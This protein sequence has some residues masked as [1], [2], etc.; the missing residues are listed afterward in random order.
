MP[1]LSRRHF[2]KGSALLV[3]AYATHRSFGTDLNS[4]IRIAVVGLHWRGG[5]LI[6]DVMRTKG[7]RLV[8]LCDVDSAELTKAAA[9]VKSKHGITVAQVSEFRTLL[10]RP[11]IDAVAIAT[12]NHWHA[13]QAIWALQAGKDVYLEKPVCHTLW[14]GR[15]IIRAASKYNK[16]VQ[17]GLQNRSDI[18]LK[19][20]FAYIQEG[21]LGAIK[22]VRGL[23][24]KNRASIG[25]RSTP[26]TP[27][28]SLNY[29]LWLGPAADQP[30]FR[31]RIHYDWHWDWN[32]G[33][34]DLGNQG[35]HELDL[36]RWVL[37]EPDHPTAV[38]SM[39]RRFAWHDAGQTPNM[40]ICKLH[41]P[42]RDVIFEV[43]NLWM[44]PETDAASHYKGHRIGVIVTCEGGEFR[45]GRGGGI[46]YDENNKKRERF[47][48]DGGYDHFPSFIRAINSRQQSDLAAPLEQSFKSTALSQL[49]NLSYQTGKSLPQKRVENYVA[50]DTNLAATYQR[51]AQH[52]DKWKIDL[53]SERWVV[54]SALEFDPATERFNGGPGHKQANAQ[55]RRNYRKGYVVPEIV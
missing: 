12:P 46:V 7:A 6:E 34:G 8:A 52:L 30:L 28:S 17:A 24:Y 29:D 44:N 21:N 11:D 2:I 19:E 25:K 1:H 47:K 37:G 22:Q 31:E 54:G 18:G 23:C 35:V 16:I 49:C 13:L 39:G 55:L 9:E 5:Q 40:Q 38:S 50:D 3:G 42:D 27:P 20:A 36:V 45:G 15:Q 4:E 10:E 43:N 41:W 32:T 14:E 53:E 33:N 51:F 26:L 48:G